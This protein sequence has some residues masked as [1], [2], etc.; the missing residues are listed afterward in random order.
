M[1]KRLYV[2]SPKF[3]DLKASD[4]WIEK[5]KKHYETL[6]II[7]LLRPLLTHFW[8]HWYFCHLSVALVSPH[9]VALYVFKNAALYCTIGDEMQSFLLKFEK[10]NGFSVKL[11]ICIYLALST[12]KTIIVKYST[13]HLCFPMQ[14]NGNLRYFAYLKLSLFRTNF[15]VCKFEIE[16]VHY[17]NAF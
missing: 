16:R 7:S 3:P 10:A 6:S 1:K 5:W 9:E 15:S 4:R 17:N 11:V 14:L 13:T 8:R 2:E 12:W